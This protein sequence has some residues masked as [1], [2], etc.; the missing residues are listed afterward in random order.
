[1]AKPT[2]K[3]TPPSDKPPFTR[4]EAGSYDPIYTRG[5]WAVGVTK[6]PKPKTEPNG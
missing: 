4:R 2:K 1:M 5:Y 3:S 6:L